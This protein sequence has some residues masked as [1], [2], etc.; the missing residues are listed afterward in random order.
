M[1]T[2]SL[3]LFTSLG[4]SAVTCQ[5]DDDDGGDDERN[6]KCHLPGERLGKKKTTDAHCRQW[7]QCT[8]D[9]GHRATD[10]FHRNNETEV[11]DHGADERKRAEVHPL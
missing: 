4:S 10:A 2:S 1:R 7:L 3:T 8:N 9:S 11:R 5:N 6:G